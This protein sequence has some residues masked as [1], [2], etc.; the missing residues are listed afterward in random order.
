LVPTTDFGLDHRLLDRFVVDDKLFFQ[1]A[2]RIRLIKALLTSSLRKRAAV[3]SNSQ[4]ARDKVRHAFIHSR[5]TATFL[6]HYL[7]CLFL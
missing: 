7:K 6:R 2:L 5:L 3:F 1:S 4:K